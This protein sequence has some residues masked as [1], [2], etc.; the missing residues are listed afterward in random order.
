MILELRDGPRLMLVLSVPEA[1][2]VTV[3]GGRKGGQ[4]RP[5]LAAVAATAQSLTLLPAVGDPVHVAVVD[6]GP[7]GVVAYAAE[8]ETP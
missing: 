7:D 1:W 8:A 2:G 6:V 3:A 5:R 4:E